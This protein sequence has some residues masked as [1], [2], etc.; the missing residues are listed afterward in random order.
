MDGETGESQHILDLRRYC[1]DL[2]VCEEYY[3]T[4]SEL[5]TEGDKGHSQIQHVEAQSSLLSQLLGSQKELESIPH[6]QPLK[7]LPCL[8]H[9]GQLAISP[10]SSLFS[11]SSSGLPLGQ[12]IS[13]V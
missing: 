11:S 7:V 12:P 6:I 10:S 8:W 5:K 9:T 1:G 13:P 2:I 3:L 4:I